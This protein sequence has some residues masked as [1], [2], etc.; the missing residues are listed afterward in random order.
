ME[1]IYFQPDVLDVFATQYMPIICMWS[2]LMMGNLNRHASGIKSVVTRDTNAPVESWMNVLKTRT[3]GSERPVRVGKFVREEYKAIRGRLREYMGNVALLKTPRKSTTKT[4][5]RS[6]EA[7]EHAKEEW[8]SRSHG[9]KKPPYYFSATDKCPEPKQPKQKN[10]TNE[11]GGRKKQQK[12][13]KDNAIPRKRKTTVDDERP[14]KQRKMNP[15]DN[16]SPKQRKTSDDTAPD[17]ERKASKDNLRSTGRDKK[18]NTSKKDKTEPDESQTEEE[19]DNTSPKQRKTSDDTVPDKE[20]KTS[21]DNLRSTG[22]DKKENTSKK[23]KTETDK[24]QKEEEKDKKNEK[25]RN[26]NKGFTH[27]KPRNKNERHEH[28]KERHN[29]KDTLPP[30]FKNVDN[31]CWLISSVQSLAAVTSLNLKGKHIE[32]FWRTYKR[33]NS[34]ILSLRFAWMYMYK[35]S[36][37]KTHNDNSN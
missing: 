35:K 22:R 2:G 23:D 9:K 16:T 28:G 32:C 24:S 10:G 30:G 6:E 18:E 33:S 4:P 37:C 3:L 1:N 15:K 19:N 8:Q 7:P 13:G 25:T 34:K 26:Q 5:P 21:K 11:T 20:G 14:K 36:L 27:T 17:K 31:T 29:R 12:T